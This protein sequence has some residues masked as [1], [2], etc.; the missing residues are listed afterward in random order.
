MT[1]VS[2][3]EQGVM[4]WRSWLLRPHEKE[5]RE[6]KAEGLPARKRGGKGVMADGVLEVF[7]GRRMGVGP[8]GMATERKTQ[9]WLVLLLFSLFSSPS[10]RFSLSTWAKIPPVNNKPSSAET[11]FSLTLS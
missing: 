5:E 7:R 11:I 9:S 8:P 4:V 2:P 6:V 1:M 3:G 10:A